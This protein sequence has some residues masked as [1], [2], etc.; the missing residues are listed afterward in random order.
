MTGPSL[1]SA[2][3]FE[4]KYAQE[5]DPWRYATSG[6]E[7][8]KFAATLAAL[9][10]RR[11]RVG[12]EVG[13]S[14][15][16]F[17]QRLAARCDRLLAVDISSMAL[18]RAR[19][20]CAGLDHVSFRRMQVPRDWVAGSFD[21]VVLS[22][23]LY[24]FTPAAIAETARRVRACLSSGGHVILVNY[25]PPTDSPVSGDQAA[26]V[27]TAAAKLPVTRRRRTMQYRIDVLE[28]PQPSEERR[29]RAGHVRSAC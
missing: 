18:R 19:M 2:A 27:F 10:D 15:G 8:E 28:A 12:F 17:T 21:L 7:H 14:I 3:F 29:G 25:L 13:C 9:P 24:Y 22:E 5:A 4:A 11:F 1:F 6:Y 26:R 23:V 16:V 20:R